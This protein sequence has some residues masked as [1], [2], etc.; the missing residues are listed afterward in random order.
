MVQ[1]AIILETLLGLGAT[2]VF[3]HRLMT[4]G[5]DTPGLL[6][7]G[8][9]LAWGSVSTRSLLDAGLVGKDGG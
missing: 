2:G 8:L 7:L 9:I 1:H 4:A 6:L 5:I 3:A